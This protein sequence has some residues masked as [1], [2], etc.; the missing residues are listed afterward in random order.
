MRWLG[1]VPS[2][3]IYRVRAL[4]VCEVLSELQHSETQGRQCV[5]AGPRALGETTDAAL[6]LDLDPYP[7]GL[8][9]DY[10]SRLLVTHR[11]RWASPLYG[12]AP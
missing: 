10:P 11:G 8:W 4:A 2:G 9:P 6:C 3:E 12:S 7:P 5:V 1:D